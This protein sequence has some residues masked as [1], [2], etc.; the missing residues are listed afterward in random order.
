M[1]AW[2]VRNFSRLCRRR[3]LVLDKFTLSAKLCMG[4]LVDNLSNIDEYLFF[5]SSAGA[6]YNVPF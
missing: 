5:V 1:K 2:D 6:I 3:V 4:S